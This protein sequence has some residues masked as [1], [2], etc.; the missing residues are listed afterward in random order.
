[1][2][3]SLDK[4]KTAVFG[5]TGSKANVKPKIAG[6]KILKEIKF[7]Q[8]VQIS[9]KRVTLDFSEN[10]SKSVKNVKILK[11]RLPLDKIQGFLKQFEANYIFAPPANPILPFLFVFGDSGL[12]TL[13]FPL[14]SYN[15]W[16]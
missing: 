1:M 12:G 13:F 15:L 11:E 2:D 6:R 10:Y 4:E 16:V 14:K 9:Q 8:N 3:A 5:N 7:F